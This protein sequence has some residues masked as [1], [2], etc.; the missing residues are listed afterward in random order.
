M[1]NSICEPV[2]TLLV[3]NRAWGD[4]ATEHGFSAWVEV[5]AMRV[6]FD[7][8][9]GSALRANAEALGVDVRTT[10]VLV[11]SHGHYDHTGGVP[12]VLE[13]APEVEVC[14]HPGLRVSRYS[15]RQGK[16]RSIGM[17][18][19]SR[20]ALGRIGPWRTITGPME[21]APGFG[22][23]GPIPRRTTYEDTGGPFF[24]DPDGDSPDPIVD[25][26]GLWVRTPRGLLVVTGCGHAGVVN[27]VRHAVEVS[28]ESRVHAVIGGFHLGEASEQRLDRTAEAFRKLGIDLIVPC[29]CTGDRAIARLAEAVGE[30]VEAG[31]AGQKYVRGHMVE[32]MP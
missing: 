7:T 8:G 6:L 32:P 19:D 12:W 16:A 14:A 20:N 13:Q 28:G 3:D 10:D 11:L 25:D 18:D 22:L 5:E 26:L 24:L 9:Q 15:I 2:V 4:L 23:T 27:T 17:P 30:R 29:H 1:T 21:L 31:R